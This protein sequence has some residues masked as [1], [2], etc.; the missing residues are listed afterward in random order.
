PMI[1]RSPFALLGR[2][3]H[4]ARSLTAFNLSCVAGLCSVSAVMLWDMRE[5]AT[6][7]T[8]LTSHSLLQVLELDIARNIE[9]YCLSLQAVVEGMK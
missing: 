2:W 5:E 9:L 8:A 3:T 4:S 7:R 1:I 6:R